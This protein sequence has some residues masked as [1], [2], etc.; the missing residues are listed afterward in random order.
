[1]EH[2]EE[3]AT[4]PPGYPDL[5]EYRYAT[6]Y[7]RAS[8]QQMKEKV[9]SLFSKMGGTLRIVIATA[10]FSMG[11]DCPNVHQII[12]WGTPTRTEQYVQKI[13]RAGRDGALS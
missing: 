7:T 6:M 3:H 13:G 9:M 1:M 8:T 11:V 12:H 5:P 10:A 4:N 2:L